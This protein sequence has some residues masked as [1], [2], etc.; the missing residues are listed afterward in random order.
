MAILVARY[1]GFLNT[2]KEKGDDGVYGQNW[3]VTLS[4]SLFHTHYLTR[5]SVSFHSAEEKEKKLQKGK[6]NTKQRGKF[7]EDCGAQTEAAAA[8]T[9][10]ASLELCSVFA[11]DQLTAAAT[12][13]VGSCVS[14]VLLLLLLLL[15]SL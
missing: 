10:V 5:R 2:E 4:F 13:A 7:G 3:C 1:S 6:A 9:V 8:A 12:A 14:M 11:L 15:L